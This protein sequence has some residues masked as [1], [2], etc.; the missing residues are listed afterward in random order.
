MYHRDLLR[1]SGSA[2]THRDLARPSVGSSEVAE[3]HL[4]SQGSAG[5]F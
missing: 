5:T 4:D 2:R 1:R 3:I